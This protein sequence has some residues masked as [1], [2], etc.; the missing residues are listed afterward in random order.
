M[1]QCRLFGSEDVLQDVQE[2]TLLP[3]W[4]VWFESHHRAAHK[5]LRVDTISIKTRRLVDRKVGPAMRHT[6]AH[7]ATSRAPAGGQT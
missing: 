1:H 2:L 3:D 5:F 6:D 7:A 4:V